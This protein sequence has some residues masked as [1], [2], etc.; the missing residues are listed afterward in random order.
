MSPGGRRYLTGVDWAVNALDYSTKQRTGH[1][2]SSQVLMILRDR[3][4]ESRLAEVLDRLA[5]EY[6]VIAGRSARAWNL[7][8]YW[9]VRAKKNQRPQLMVKHF[10]QYDFDRIMAES[11]AWVNQDFS[12]PR[13]HLRFCLMQAGEQR[14]CLALHF[15]HR[16]L[17]AFGAELMLELLARMDNGTDGEVV[18]RTNLTEPMRLGG[19]RRRFRAGRR[20]NRRRVEL[21]RGGFATLPAASGKPTR[22][23]VL[24]FN[25]RQT[26]QIIDTAYRE[27]G[28]LLLLP[29]LLARVTAAF[30]QLFGA[31]GLKPDNY[32][33][34]ITVVQRPPKT[35]W[36]TLFFNHLS[37]LFLQIPAAAVGDRRRLV[38]IVRSQLYQQTRDRMAEH[39]VDAAM[40]TRIAPLPVLHWL[41][42][43][44]LGRMTGSFYFSCLKQTAFSQPEFLGAQ[45]ENI[46]HTPHMPMPPG[47]GVTMNLFQD[48]L[49]LTLSCGQGILHGQEEQTLINNL[50][51]SFLF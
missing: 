20:I 49:N 31:R 37:F 12:S 24:S 17:D 18:R 42:A 5:R 14:S 8:P 51:Q 15:D 46:I 39:I 28:Y 1:G 6:P 48:R 40:L 30:D 23:Q 38:D 4:P 50:R 10:E 35:S 36:E 44:T 47:L 7:C 22:F 41:S 27:A 26:A 34:P 25:P 16:L 11:E 3:L 19:W 43:T 45:V 13:Q 2:N 29:S 33:V 21:I 32:V 9:R